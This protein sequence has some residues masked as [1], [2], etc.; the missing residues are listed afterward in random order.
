MNHSL[1]DKIQTLGTKLYLLRVSVGPVQEFISEA[2]K[3]RDLYM[4]SQLLSE[5]TKKS[6]KPIIDNYGRD[7]V[8]YPYI[9]GY[10]LSKNSIPNLYMAVIPENGLDT[11]I[12]LMEKKYIFF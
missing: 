2:R 3:T 5:V 9:Q 4:G 8:I 11:I 12:P 1:S 7:A 6:M 10:E